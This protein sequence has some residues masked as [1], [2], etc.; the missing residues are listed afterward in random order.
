MVA[1]ER[2]S[3][4]QRWVVAV[5]VDLLAWLATEL[6]ATFPRTQKIVALVAVSLVVVATL[7]GVTF[8]QSGESATPAPT[9]VGTPTPVPVLELQ[10]SPYADAAANIR[11]AT[12]T[13]APVDCP[14]I[15]E[16]TRR[17]NNF[18]SLTPGLTFVCDQRGE[19]ARPIAPGRIVMRVIQA[20]LNSEK[21]EIVAN[22]KD[23]PWVRAAAYGNFVVVD[24]GPLGGVPNVTSVYAGL[25]SIPESLRL[26]QQVDVTTELGTLGAKLI[27]GEL[28]PGVLTFELL[29]DDTRFG[30][31]P[32]RRNPP[33]A[34]SSFE[35][36]QQ[37]GPQL[38]LPIQGCNLPF[39]NPDLNVGAPR[40]YRSGT[41][42][43]LDFNCGT[44]DHD[45]TAAADGEVLF[46]VSDYVDATPEDRDAVLANSALAVDTPF[47]T[48]AMLYGNFV[49]VAHPLP[50]SGDQIV[51]IYAHLSEVD[52]EI[53]TGRVVTQGMR[54]GSV[55]NTGTSASAEGISD[56]HVSVHLHWELHVNDRA[57]G[58]LQD[59]ADTE[60]LYVSMLCSPGAE[61]SITG[62]C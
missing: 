12:G 29:S 19:A 14:F 6:M 37:L 52:D 33:P 2:M 36:A 47:W 25:E 15:D 3:A 43:G 8:T 26:G 51:S 28:V 57:I 23:G 54:L 10:R 17:D 18:L 13:S 60:P 11:G 34:S 61:P 4:G 7:V 56:N 32:L 38:A 46:V 27:N 53:V 20:P 1:P 62:A 41:H 42:N 45:I 30:A 55:G 50:E 59:P 58:Y 35:L 21:A 49:V 40:A 22:G 44:T 24:H 31:D 5:T 39:G 48:L 16:R 9:P